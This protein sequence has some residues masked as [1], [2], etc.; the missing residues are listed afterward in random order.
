MPS[1]AASAASTREQECPES[2]VRLCRTHWQQQHRCL[3]HQLRQADQ[4]Q[5]QPQQQP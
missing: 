3:G 5:Q 4:S 1:A 2:Q